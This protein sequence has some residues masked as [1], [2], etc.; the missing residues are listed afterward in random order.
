MVFESLVAN[1][2]ALK[3][4]VVT[5]DVL[6]TGVI[7]GWF[8]TMNMWAKSIGTGVFLVGLYMMKRYSTS[9][10]FFK[11]AIPLIGIVFIGI[12]LLFTLLDL[13]QPFRF[14]HMFVY[15]H[16]TSVINIGSWFLNLYV[17][18]L[19]LM[20]Y[21]V[22]IKKDDVL[23][24][25]L[26]LP[27]LFLAFV[28]TIYTAGLMGQSNARE[29]WQTPTE[30]AQMLLAAGI[31]GSAAF[32]LTGL[33]LSKE[34][35][36]T[37][38]GILGLCATLSFVIFLSEIFFAPV[39]SE[40]AEWIIHYITHGGI[41]PLFYLGMLLAFIIPMALIGLSLK[42]GTTKLLT[43]ASASALVGLWMMKHTWL[44]APQ[45]IPLS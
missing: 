16:F 2:P 22:I 1:V 5:L 44:V 32:L 7:W 31:G 34:E 11:A 17:A 39:K 26:K 14:W 20:A 35:K 8:V 10:N 12:T 15:P 3:S 18:L 27:G 38:A 33:A 28:A 30:I 36:M 37:L 43:I 13:H 25:R 19:T 40:E 6:H 42:T 24:D 29:I 9:Q 21:A 4:A 45:M 23:F 41:A